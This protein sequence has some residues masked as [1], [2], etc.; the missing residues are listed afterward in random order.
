M[1]K[2]LCG[3]LGA[4]MVSDRGCGLGEFFYSFIVIIMVLLLFSRFPQASVRNLY[5]VYF[6]NPLV[7]ALDLKSMGRSFVTSLKVV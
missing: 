4:R 5:I 7:K 3:Y 2:K 1:K 6:F